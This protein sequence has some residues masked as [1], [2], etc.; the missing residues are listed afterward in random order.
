[1]GRALTWLL[2]G[3]FALGCGALG[4]VLVIVFAGRPLLDE[5]AASYEERLVDRTALYEMR[6][7]LRDDMSRV[8]TRLERRFGREGTTE[9]AAPREP[10]TAQWRLGQGF[11]CSG[12]LD[13]AQVLLDNPA[14]P[15]GFR[16]ERICVVED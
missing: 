6:A 3:I 13:T 1:M 9:V 12:T 5:G 14:M 11:D 7:D 2:Q 10:E 16:G 8:E 15:G 4:A